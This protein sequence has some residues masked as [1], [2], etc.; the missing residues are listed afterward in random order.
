MDR[1]DAGARHIRQVNLQSMSRH[2]SIQVE[3]FTDAL[4]RSPLFSTWCSERAPDV[5]FGARVS[6]L[7]QD[8]SGE[9]SLIVHWNERKECSW[10]KTWAHVIHCT[11][12][13]TPTRFV[14]VIPVSYAE[15]ILGSK[16]RK[17]LELAHIPSGSSSLHRALSRQWSLCPTA[18][19]NLSL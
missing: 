1:I 15:Y 4:H 14:L 3:C 5:E 8:L 19:H 18:E 17:V 7:Q 6:F 2:L 10:E 13:K 11:S 9:S 16:S 12:S